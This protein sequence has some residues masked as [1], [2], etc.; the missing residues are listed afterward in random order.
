MNRSSKQRVRNVKERSV[1]ERAEEPVQ[2]LPPERSGV[3]GEPDQLEQSTR[4]EAKFACA[5]K[6]DNEDR[7]RVRG[8]PRGDRTKQ[9]ERKRSTEPTNRFEES[10]ESGADAV[11]AEAVGLGAGCEESLLL[12]QVGS[13]SKTR[14][15]SGRPRVVQPN[16][17]ILVQLT[18]TSSPLQQSGIRQER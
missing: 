3:R 18:L 9:I 14:S 11:R 1:F 12:E 5:S 4:C 2:R 16:F 6:E 13:S 8:R 10:E 17:H 15:I 7:E